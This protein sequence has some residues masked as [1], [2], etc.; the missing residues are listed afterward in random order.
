MNW[1]E[2]KKFGQFQDKERGLLGP[3]ERKKER[4]PASKGDAH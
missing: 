3:N 2:S 4:Q 1:D